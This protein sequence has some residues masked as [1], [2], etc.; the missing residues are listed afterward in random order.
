M[1][2]EEKRIPP[3][4][5]NAFYIDTF[6]PEDADGIVSLFRSVYGDGYPIKLFYDREAIIAANRDGS[7]ISIVARTPDGEVIGVSHLYRSAPY[8][9]LYEAG[10]GLVLKDYRN[11]GASK[12]TLFYLF[13]EF[14]PKN[15]QI[16]ELFGE[17][18]CNHVFMQKTIP[19][20]RHIETAIEVALMP[21][22]AYT[23]EKSAQGRVAALDAFRCYVT[24][25]HQIFLPHVYEEILK[26]TYAR[27]DYD[28]TIDISGGELPS[29]SPT[30]A[31]LTIFDF[32]GVARIAVEH[33]GSDFAARISELESNARAKN[34]IVFQVW[35][36]LTEPWVGRAT[37]LLREKGYFY[38][39][40][41]PR[42][43]DGDG[44]LMQK[45]ECD[46]DFE[47]I[48][49]YAD[50]SKKLM[51]FIQRDRKKLYGTA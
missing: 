40:A 41:L 4:N 14:V 24:K 34:V 35:L 29:S 32:A 27:L 2:N 22:E 15:P 20:S 46:P 25:P 13:N 30:R 33:A 42:W 31:E 26:R 45:T 23:T 48:V 17:A 28:R 44:L 51:E 50:F 10:V 1:S 49:L 16:E 47:H 8:S 43:F 19:P 11:S 7:Y 6:R 21:A 12:A 38:G 36:N 3:Q 9:G 37:E 39:G 5:Q 18:V